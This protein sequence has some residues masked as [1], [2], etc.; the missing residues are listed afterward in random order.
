LTPAQYL[1]GSI[2]VEATARGIPTTYRVKGMFFA[3]LVEQL[4]D[5]FS[6]VEPQLATPP[7]FGRYVPF[8]D[9]PQSDYVRLTTA[10]AQKL[11]PNVPL[12]EGVRRLGRD[13][14]NVLATSTI[15]KI[16]LAAV[17]DAR[18]V[19]LKA[20]FIYEKLAPGGWTVTGE[21]ID[22]VTVRIEFAPVYGTWEYTLGQLEGV[23]L[24]FGGTPRTTVSELP[25]RK[26]Q[27]DVQ[28]G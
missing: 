5:G 26:V 28:H 11:Y 13:D 17:G 1:T 10:T 6:Q 3:R 24:N 27:F 9:Y 20:P 18:S 25:M 23:I 4:G 21:P 2:D 16:T 22:D 7:R 15:G 19:L 12:R 14:F 8:S